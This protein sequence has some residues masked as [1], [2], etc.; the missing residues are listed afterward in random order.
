MPCAFGEATRQKIILINKRK[1]ITMNLKNLFFLTVICWS[2]GIMACQP[3]APTEPETLNSNS[4]FT[5]EN[6]TP[7]PGVEQRIDDFE[8]YLALTDLKSG[9]LESMRVEDV[10]WSAEAML[11]RTYT[12]VAHQFE[13]L[14]TQTDTI[15]IAHTG[16]MMPA[17]EVRSFYDGALKKFSEHFYSLPADN[18][19]PIL[20]DVAERADDPNSLIVTTQ[21]GTGSGSFVL[22][23]HDDWWWGSNIGTCDSDNIDYYDTDYGSSDGAEQ[24]E[25]QLNHRI[26]QIN[27]IELIPCHM[28]N[29]PICFSPYYAVNVEIVSEEIWPTI[30]NSSIFNPNDDVPGDNY[31]DY[32]LY[33]NLHG[34]PN[35]GP[36]KCISVEDM[37]FYYNSAV[38]VINM[39]RPMNKDFIV[40]DME[41]SALWGPFNDYDGYHR[42]V[43]SYGRVIRPSPPPDSGSG[44]YEM[45]MLP[46]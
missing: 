44:R 12:N 33:F 38:D 8:T 11:N 23:F 45:Q 42:M 31:K 25:I 34:T 2:L 16:R 32:L 9:E 27:G 18:R 30:F 35:W 21:V 17:H 41:G 14:H 7:N 36:N 46:M 29:P 19:L 40:A 39:F 3:E 28:T 13:Q 24:I 6:A 43:P 20:V 15:S 1:I 26:A 5:L 22:G 4:P 37:D 10:T